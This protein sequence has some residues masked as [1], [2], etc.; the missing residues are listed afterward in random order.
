MNNKGRESL[1]KM[2]DFIF[3]L[4]GIL[5]T[6]GMIV[7]F[8]LTLPTTGFIAALLIGVAGTCGLMWSL[9]TLMI[10]LKEYFKHF[11]E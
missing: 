5:I 3:I 4:L 11:M 6:I 10:S 2:C 9:Y 7:L 8:I 1:M